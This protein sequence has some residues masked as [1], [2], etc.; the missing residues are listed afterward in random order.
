MEP[1]PSAPL[2]R[3]FLE[4][5]PGIGPR[6]AVHL[7][8][9][10]G[11]ELPTIL[12][13]REA[14]RR[15]LIP[16]LDPKRGAA[17]VK[18][19]H[20]MHQRWP[21]AEAAYLAHSWLEAHG[22]DEPALAKRLVA[23]CGADAL[24][25]LNRNPYVI[26]RAIAWSTL[27]AI[28]LAILTTRLGS[29]DAH[30]ADERL[31]GACDR[32]MADVVSRG[33]TSVTLTDYHQLVAKLL[34]RKPADPTIYRAIDLAISSRRIIVL[35]DLL[36]SPGCAWMERKIAV[37]LADWAEQVGHGASRAAAG[38]TRVAVR[39]PR[40]LH[41]EQRIAIERVLATR[42]SILTGG[43]GTGKTSALR[44]VA[45][46]WE[47]LG[48]T[49]Q[50]ATLSGKAALRLSQATG[51]LAK[52]IHRM[53]DELEREDERSSA[54]SSAHNASR[55]D[56]RTLLIIDEASM[57]DL[58]QWMRLTE[59]V[60]KSDAHL[61]A[62]GDVA[63]LPPIGPGTVFHSLAAQD[64]WCARLTTIHRQAEDNG[65]PQTALAVRECR[66]LEPVPY[67]GI[68]EGVSL[69]ESSENEVDNAVARVVEDLGGFS[70]ADH[71]LQIVAALNRTVSRLNA[72][73]HADLAG[74]GAELKG[75]FGNW[76]RAGDP[77]VHLE[78]D[79][80]AGLYNGLLGHVARVD[81]SR[82]SLVAIFEGKEH[83]FA[84]ERLLRLRLAY[85]LTCHKLQGSQ[86]RRVIIVLEAT[87]LID[88]SWLYTA[89]TRAE[90]QAVL[91]GSRAAL[92]ATMQRLPAHAIRVTALAH[93]I[94]MRRS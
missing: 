69:F 41:S 52:T 48:G 24:Q 77:I 9:L 15:R 10:F 88:P 92:A 74:P 38:L 90:Q 28:G 53:L 55:L 5:F 65:I 66:A 37:R 63:Q 11:D 13:D 51:R 30:T 6:R 39:L 21:G 54:R 84:R 71:N 18:I 34:R 25:I 8:T 62:V 26:A 91:V 61:L 82:R 22:I 83:V 40:P 89:I 43:A 49:V 78:N 57:V 50:L 67:R 76:F 33:H 75:E 94:E 86:A 23:F 19:G 16:A 85:A 73:F 93:E 64:D 36:R 80:Q 70:A 44:A 81:Q 47:E 68:G 79:Y 60:E 31:M 14:V 32:V 45:D 27:D 4:S 87:R 35:G 72:K 58:G 29:A 42:F 12:H 20:A 2:R 59:E 7:V 3:A 17:A 46:T 56:S 1:R